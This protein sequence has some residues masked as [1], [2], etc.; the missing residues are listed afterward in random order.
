ME[1]D[2]VLIQENFDLFVEAATDGYRQ[3][4]RGVVMYLQKVDRGGYAPASYFTG[5][6][7]RDEQQM[8]ENYEPDT[9][10]VICIVHDD[11]T[12]AVYR[13]DNKLVFA[14]RN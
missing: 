2:L 12:K 1:S 7:S 10:F 4:G 14:N 6:E 9:Q 5:D 11:N 3:H 13:L 8:L